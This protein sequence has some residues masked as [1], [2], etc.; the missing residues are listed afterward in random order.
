METVSIMAA[1]AGAWRLDFREV[2]INTGRLVRM[3]LQ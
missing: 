3:L 1:L 2:R